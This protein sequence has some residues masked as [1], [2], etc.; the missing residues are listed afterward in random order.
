MSGDAADL[1]QLPSESLWYRAPELLLGAD[2]FSTAVDMW[3][4][5]WANCLFK[6]RSDIGCIWLFR[7]HELSVGV[8][9]STSGAFLA[10]C[11]SAS[12]CLPRAPT[13]Y[14]RCL[15]LARCVAHRLQ[16]RGRRLWNFLV[17]T[18]P[19]IGRS[20]PG[21]YWVSSAGEWSYCPS[22]CQRIVW[23]WQIF[24]PSRIRNICR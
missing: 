11:S 6:E 10:K 18:W 17:S 16:S 9:V 1:R 4:S 24:A 19:R 15:Q 14:S 23:C 7:D 12:R 3:S 5:G 21:G 20:A 13:N 22:V 2:K 8:Y